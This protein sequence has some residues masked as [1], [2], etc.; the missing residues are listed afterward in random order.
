MLRSGAHTGSLW[1]SPGR[2]NSFC[3]PGPGCVGP[4]DGHGLELLEIELQKGVHRFKS[5]KS[6]QLGTPVSNCWE[7]RILGAGGL[8]CRLL[9]VSMGVT[10]IGSCVDGDCWLVSFLP[11]CPSK[12]FLRK[13]PVR[14][15]PFLSDNRRKVLSLHAQRPR[16]RGRKEA[17]EEGGRRKAGLG[18]EKGA[19]A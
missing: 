6:I 16:R 9:G 13:T 10:G 2:A 1:D 7:I 12:S 5:K 15:G 14:P 19:T 18:V 3:V 4:P 8:G 17:E 11:V